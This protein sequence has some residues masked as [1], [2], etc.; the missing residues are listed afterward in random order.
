MA[1]ELPIVLAKA[2][3]DESFRKAVIFDSINTFS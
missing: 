3:K 1:G 2:K